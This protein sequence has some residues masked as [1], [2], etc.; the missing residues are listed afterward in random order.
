ML[1][2]STGYNDALMML[3]LNMAD[4]PQERIAAAVAIALDD[5][6]ELFELMLCHVFVG[7]QGGIR[8]PARC[9]ATVRISMVGRDQ[10]QIRFCH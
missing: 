10:R 5:L 9:R 2:R 8:R 4:P 1:R 7:S 3:R 6:D